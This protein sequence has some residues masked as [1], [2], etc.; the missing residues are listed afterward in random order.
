[1]SSYHTFSSGS[2]VNPNNP[3]AN[4]LP[5]GAPPGCPSD[6]P[7]PRLP[8]REAALWQGIGGEMNRFYRVPDRDLTARMPV[9]VPTPKDPAAYVYP[10]FRS[11]SVYRW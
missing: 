2:D 11:A 1:M 7:M 3:Y 4:P 8:D 9:G 10:D 5:F 6:A